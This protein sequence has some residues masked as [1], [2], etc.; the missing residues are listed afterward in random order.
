MLGVFLIAAFAEEEKGAPEPVPSQWADGTRADR[1]LAADIKGMIRIFEGAD[2]P[3]CAFKVV[4]QFHSA[5]RPGV[6]R[7]DEL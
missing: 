1:Q 2:H 5:D 6:E 7:W 4:K 3:H